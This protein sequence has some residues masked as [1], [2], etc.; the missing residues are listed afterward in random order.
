MKIESSSVD[1]SV[2]RLTPTFNQR[3]MSSM[4]RIRDGQTT[5]IAGV[6]QDTQS[7][8]VKGIPFIGL[9]PILGRFFATPETQDTQSDVVIT[10]TPHILRRA[11][12]REEDHYAKYSGDG[13]N[14][15]NQLSI[16]QILY[17]ADQEDQQQAPPVAANPAAPEAKPAMEKA[18]A[19][20][21][22]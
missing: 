19:P 1:S 16:A 15:F 6:T 4:A 9:V 7:T 3:T 2:S 17:L 10:V 5:L 20:P 22:Q 14:A 11:D 8:R 18:V 21:T 12:I 13:V